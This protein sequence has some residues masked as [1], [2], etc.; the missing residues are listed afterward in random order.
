VD[1]LLVLG[2]L[3]QRGATGV[4]KIGQGGKVAAHAGPVHALR[5]RLPVAQ[6]GS[7]CQRPASR[8][9]A[10]PRFELPS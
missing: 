8:R 3:S 10:A 5:R 4:R 2:D 1:L 9:T 7:R 6:P